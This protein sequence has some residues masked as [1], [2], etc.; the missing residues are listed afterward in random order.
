MS[1]SEY[2]KQANLAIQHDSSLH[3]KNDF[4]P[5]NQET[6]LTS[7]DEYHAQYNRLESIIKF[8]LPVVTRKHLL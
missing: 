1:E 7:A 6:A 5:L 2:Q 3:S 8:N 4:V